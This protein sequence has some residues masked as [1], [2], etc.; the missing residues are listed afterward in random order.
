MLQTTRRLT[1]AIIALV[2]CAALPAASQTLDEDLK[3]IASDATVDDHFGYSIAVSNGIVAAGAIHDD[4]NG[5]NSGSAYLFDASTGAQLYKLLPSDGAPSDI[6]GN[7]IAIDNGIVAVGAR[8]NDDNGSGSGSAYLFD[9]STGAQLFKLTA[10]HGG[11]SDLFGYSIAIDNNIVA[12]AAYFDFFQGSAGS[13]YSF[14]ASTGEQ[15]AQFNANDGVPNLSFGLSIDIDNGVVVVGSP[16]D[17]E[18][19]TNSGAA[20]LFDAATGVQ[21]AKLLPN[22]GTGG[23]RFGYSVAIENGVVAV[24]ARFDDNE[25]NTDSGSAYLFDASTGDQLF[26]LLPSDIQGLLEFGNTIAIHNDIVV[27]G[28]VEDYD[29]GFGSGS[30]YIFDATTGAQLY[31]LLPNDGASGDQFGN[32]IAIHNDNVVVGAFQN[33]DNGSRSGSAYIFDFVPPTFENLKITASDGVASDFFGRSIAIDNTT[34]AVGAR[35]DDDNGSNSGSAYIFD[36]S[37]GNETT[38]LLPTDGAQ[39]DQFGTSIAIDSTVAITGAFRDD[40]NGPNSG[41]AYLFDASTGAQLIKLLPTDGAPND[42]FGFSVAIDNGVAAVGS[43]LDDDNGNDS[44]SAYLFDASTGTQLFK[45]LPNNGA[46]SDQ[47]G[48]SIAIDSGIAA[49]G[50]INADNNG[51]GSGAAYLFDASTGAQL[52]KLLPAD[53]AAGD[54]FGN[55]IAINN[56][57]VAVGAHQDDDSGT[58]SGSAYLFDA[59]TGTQIAKLLPRDGAAFDTFGFSIAIDDSVVAVGRSRDDVNGSQSG[60]AYL[61]DASTGAYIAKLLTTD[62]A[63]GDQFGYSIAIA[64]GTVAAGAWY[65]DDNG[66]DSGSIYVFNPST[67]PSCPADLTAD[68]TLDFFDISTFLTLFSSGDLAADFTNDAQLDFFDISAFLTAFSAGCP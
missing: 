48:Y 36:A 57:I 55:S 24:G 50:A 49:V 21:L 52:F 54:Q 65:D 2:G 53:G 44:G 35:G 30:A 20:Y 31:K 45:L 46:A 11:P 62:G 13:V 43:F 9:A 3:L 56:G 67:A 26:K 6:F 61:F 39:G 19:G 17:N 37:T 10:K 47:F 14:N 42:S 16:G 4:D 32:S 63:G 27:V 68:G 29:N 7:S 60:S 22:D 18:N 34:I 33:D 58:N 51:N 41:S 66:T 15:I 12:V 38:K 5:S 23:D 64:N 1:L 8:N 25:D 40:D 28:A 59:S